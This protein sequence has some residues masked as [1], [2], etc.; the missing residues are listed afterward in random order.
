MNKNEI[1]ELISIIIEMNKLL[2][3]AREKNRLAK[4]IQFLKT[5][6]LMSE[7]LVLNL[8]QDKT[9]LQEI[10]LESI[11][12][13]GKDAD[14]VALSNKKK[15]YI[16]IKA[17]ASGFQYLGKKDIVADYLI[18]IDLENPLRKDN[19][20][21]EIYIVPAP[22]EFFVKPRKIMLKKFI[23]ITRPKI[24]EL[25]IIEYLNKKN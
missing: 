23:E 5:P 2:L 9:I 11:R 4:H 3:D 16:E 14:I 22:S 18:W 20:R 12:L 15:I 10:D 21:I 24:K 1:L 7:S 25:D 8:L 17:T 6:H 13:G 19:N